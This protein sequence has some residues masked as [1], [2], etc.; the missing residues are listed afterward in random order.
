M[1]DKWR[2][3]QSEKKDTRLAIRVRDYETLKI[4]EMKGYLIF[5]PN[6]LLMSFFLAKKSPAIP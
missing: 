4:L 3:R 6:P 2:A 5:T 1:I